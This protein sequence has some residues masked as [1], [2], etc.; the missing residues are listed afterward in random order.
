MHF[1][2]ITDKVHVCVTTTPWFFKQVRRYLV[3]DQGANESALMYSVSYCSWT[4]C[5]NTIQLNAQKSSLVRICLS[6]LRSKQ[7]MKIRDGWRKRGAKQT[8][9][10]SC[11][12][13]KIKKREVPNQLHV[14]SEAL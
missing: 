1:I 3:R 6:H 11:W 9:M 4:R 14:N 12:A 7:L 13:G 5:V 8:T 10:A 2:G